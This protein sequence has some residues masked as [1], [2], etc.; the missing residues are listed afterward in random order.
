MSEH[1]TFWSLDQ[2]H[3]C[4]TPAVLPLCNMLR[5]DVQYC[6]MTAGAV[7]Y[8][9]PVVAV[10]SGTTPVGYHRYLVQDMWLLDDSIISI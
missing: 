10:T 4:N 2:S 6:C 3:V 5:D 7:R 8:G 1:Y 9:R